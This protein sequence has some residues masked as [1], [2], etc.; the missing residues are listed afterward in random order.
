MPIIKFTAEEIRDP[1]KSRVTLVHTEDAH[2]CYGEACGI[3][4][5]ENGKA[6]QPGPH[7]HL[8]ITGQ[9][10]ATTPRRYPISK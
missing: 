7:S 5:E 1:D 8:V 2:D 4:H 3:Y 10:P 6:L 9:D